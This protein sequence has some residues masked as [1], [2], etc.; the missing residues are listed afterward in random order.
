[1]YL[2]V[3]KAVAQA[4]KI[5]AGSM[6]QVNLRETLP[7]SLNFIGSSFQPGLFNFLP[8]GCFIILNIFFIYIPKLALI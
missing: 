5:E 4:E 8:M 3:K 2:L 7:L 1:M 6:V